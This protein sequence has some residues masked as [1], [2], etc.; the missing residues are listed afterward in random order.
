M[1]VKLVYFTG[2]GNTEFISKRMEEVIRKEV[3][4]KELSLADAESVESVLDNGLSIDE[5]L[6]LGIGY[7][8]YDYM[9]PRVVKEFCES[10]ITQMST[11]GIKIKGVFFYATYASAHLDSHA[12]LFEMFQRAGVPVYNQEYFKGTGAS[13][14]LYMGA[15]NPL[16]KS[17]KCFETNI[18]DKV[19][20]FITDTYRRI[21]ENEVIDDISYN[22]FNRIHQQFS[23]VTFGLLFYRNLKVN[24]QC[25]KCGKCVKSCPDSNLSINQNG[26]LIDRPNHCMKCLKCVTTC[27]A[28]AINFTSRGRKGDYRREDIRELYFRN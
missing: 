16:T 5:D 12:H 7:P 14:F 8:I 18:D 9:P 26:V 2:T 27:P 20:S 4:G 22:R 1:T 10:V 3:E 19:K 24:D 15:N 11:T 6:V 13:A 23:K 25:T 21:Q 17:H 28:K